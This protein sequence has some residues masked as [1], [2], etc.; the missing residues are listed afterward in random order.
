MNTINLSQS[1]NNID[2]NPTLFDKS[3]ST[4]RKKYKAEEDLLEESRFE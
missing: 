4:L 1:I 2:R 3:S